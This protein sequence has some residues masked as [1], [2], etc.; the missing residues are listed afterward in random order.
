MK[1]GLPSIA[2]QDRATIK[3]LRKQRDVYRAKIK[4]LDWI[5][6][7]PETRLKDGCYWCTIQIEGYTRLKCFEVV[8]YNGDW[9]CPSDNLIDVSWTITHYMPIPTLPEDKKDG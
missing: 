7:T 9:D 1:N 5:P 8:Y 2:A 3:H 4:A 6:V